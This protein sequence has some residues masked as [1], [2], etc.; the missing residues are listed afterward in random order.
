MKKRIIATILSIALMITQVPWTALDVFAQTTLDVVPGSKVSDADTTDGWET[1]FGTDDSGNVS[2]E[3]AGAV[4]A[5]KSVFAGSKEFDDIQGG[6][7]V[8]LAPGTD[9]FLVAMS[10]MSSTKQITGFSYL[11]TDTVLTLDL[12]GSMSDDDLKAMVQAA[13]EAIRK[14][15]E[16]SNYNRVGIAVYNLNSYTLMPIDRYTTTDSNG[17]YLKF[18]KS[19]STRYIDVAD[20]VKSSNG[21]NYVNSVTGRSGTYTQGGMQEG[22][23][24]LLDIEDTTIETGNIQGGTKRIPVMVLMTDGDPT[25]GTSNYLEATNANR[26]IGR[27]NY[28]ETT[29]EIVFLAQLTAA[30]VRTQ[31]EAHYGRECLFYT[32]GLG[33]SGNYAPQMLQP[34]TTGTTVATAIDTHWRN[35]ANEST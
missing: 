31:M 15:Y 21:N 35:Y 19:G 13:N 23:E 26:N 16:T 20:G 14:L 30:N 8:T 6:D 25:S 29:D 7:S 3:F 11:P 10:A 22:L 32:L 27:D 28:A 24:L 12:S 34:Q 2:T 33:V 1:Y 4:W 18:R 5:D 17:D 9:N